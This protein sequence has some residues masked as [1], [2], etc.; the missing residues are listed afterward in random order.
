M[1]K[2]HQKS[3]LRYFTSSALRQHYQN[4]LDD[5]K[6]AHI[7]EQIE[8][9]KKKLK[10]R[11]E[12]GERPDAVTSNFKLFETSNRNS[13]LVEL[14][15]QPIDI[16]PSGLKQ[17]WTKRRSGISAHMQKFIPQRHAML[18]PDLATAHFLVH[19]GGSVRF[20]G[21]K[22]WIK[23]DDKEEYDLPNTFVQ[24]LVLEE[25]K[26]DGI[27]LF[28]E[29]M[30]NIQRLR[31][32]TNLSFKNV[33]KFDDWY[34]DRLSG[35]EL[36]ALEI[37]NLTGTAVTDRGLNCLYRLPSLKVLIVDDPE[38]DIMWKLSVAL[39]EEWNPKLVVK[40]E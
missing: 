21:Q 23:M 32:L 22:D 36:P 4:G 24:N 19:R 31:C 38:R 27:T 11:L 26:C 37:L 7:R 13:E 8:A 29:G 35:S 18:G 12:Y 5:P 6:L 2:F 34:L 39:L 33:T 20:R 15:Q 10:W 14:L 40:R 9:D 3:I 25:I 1:H 30:E 28:Y 16:S 17:W